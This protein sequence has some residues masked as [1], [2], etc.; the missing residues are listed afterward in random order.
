MEYFPL[1]NLAA[2]ILRLPF[3]PSETAQVCSRSLQALEYLHSNSIT[4]RDIKPENILV[5]SRTP[6]LH[7][8]LADFGLSN[9]TTALRTFCGTALYAAPE[10]SSKGLYSNT[11]DIWSLGVVILQLLVGLPEDLTWWKPVIR[12]QT[13]IRHLNVWR[14]KEGDED[15]LLNLLARMLQYD[16]AKRPSA[17]SC[18]LPARDAE[19]EFKRAGATSEGDVD[20]AGTQ[21]SAHC[22]NLEM[23][24]AK[25]PSLNPSPAQQGI[26]QQYAPNK[27]R[28]RPSPHTSDS[29]EI[30]EPKRRRYYS[31]SPLKSLRHLSGQTTVIVDYRDGTPGLMPKNLGSQV[32]TCDDN[33][34]DAIRHTDELDSGDAST[35]SSQETE[36]TH[37]EA[38]TGSRDITSS[39]LHHGQLPSQTSSAPS[40]SSQRGLTY[41]SGFGDITR[42]SGCSIPDLRQ[43]NTGL[44][45][46]Y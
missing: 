27:A 33:E 11:V 42:L 4:H 1:G 28:E 14:D 35:S 45:T 30:P 32:S 21:T 46:E 2:E 23:A 39:G 40:E 29:G 31:P 7:I 3:T 12:C 26:T 34:N 10:I 15:K 16:Q 6:T 37:R 9:N 13:I 19:L 20:S 44:T 8:R 18:T 25:I 43:R 36:T 22:H 5:E 38:S 41:P 17:R 24:E